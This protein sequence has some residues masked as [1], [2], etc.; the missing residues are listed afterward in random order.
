MDTMLF[1]EALLSKPIKVNEQQSK[2]HK[3]KSILDHRKKNR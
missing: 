2:W 3:L 1:Y